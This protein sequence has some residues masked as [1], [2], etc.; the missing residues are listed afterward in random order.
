MSMFVQI[1]LISIFPTILAIVG[2]DVSQSVSQEQFECLK[3]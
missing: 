3:G 1:I 2:V